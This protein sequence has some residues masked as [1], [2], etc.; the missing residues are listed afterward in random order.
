MSLFQVLKLIKVR[1]GS[2]RPAQKYLVYSGVEADEGR[3]PY[4]TAVQVGSLY[5]PQPP[6]LPPQTQ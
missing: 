2:K 4:Y 6:Q 3:L 5:D 1:P